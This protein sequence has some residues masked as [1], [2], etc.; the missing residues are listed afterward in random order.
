MRVRLGGIVVLL[1]QIAEKAL[2][3]RGVRDDQTQ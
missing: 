1:K 2:S 3:R